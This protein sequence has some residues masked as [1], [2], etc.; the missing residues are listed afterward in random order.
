MKFHS[1]LQLHAGSAV[2]TGNALNRPRDTG[3]M[4]SCTDAF[5]KRALLL[6]AGTALIAKARDIKRIKCSAGKTPL[7]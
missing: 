3:G 1:C 5:A 7:R 2:R 4:M 6:S